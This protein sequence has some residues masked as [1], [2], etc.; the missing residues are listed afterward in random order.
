MVLRDGS[1]L[2]LK[3][4]EGASEL[5]KIYAGPELLFTRPA[6]PAIT[7]FLTAPAY[8][9]AGGTNLP[10]NFIVEASNATT[11]T[12]TDP[13]DNVIDYTASPAA[14]APDVDTRYTLTA[15]NVEG[16]AVSHYDFI[17][18]IAPAFA[19]P[20]GITYS[21]VGTTVGVQYR[22]RVAWNVN[23][24]NPFPRL[25]WIDPPAAHPLNDPNR[26]TTPDGQG[27]IHL[28]FTPGADAL[29]IP[30]VL[31]ATN[32]VSEETA[33]ATGTVRIPARSG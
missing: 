22:V 28:T 21:Q 24:G 8:L 3:V 9:A 30:L 6:L 11:L 1:D 13:N 25:Q 15:T 31:R 16:S 33:E 17:R 2:V 4:Y 27:E 12:V 7:R 19:G 5:D 23:A 29:N 18:T 26:A 10:L 32:R 14:T 20:L